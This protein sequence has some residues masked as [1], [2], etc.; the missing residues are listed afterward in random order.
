MNLHDVLLTPWRAAQASLRWFAVIVFGLCVT[1]AAAAAL[2]LH[3]P[4]QWPLAL[5]IYS[6]GVGF[7]WAFFMPANFLLALDARR[8]S[9]PAIEHTAILALCLIA[10]ATVLV[11]VLAFGPALGVAQVAAIVSLMVAM[12]FSFAMLP[13]YLSM[14]I[15]MLPML[16]NVLSRTIPFPHLG[17][18]RIA[19]WCATAA[20]VFGLGCVLSWRRL[21]AQETDHLGLTGALVMHFRRNASM[22]TSSTRG[23]DGDRLIRQRSA[24]LQPEADLHDIGPDAPAASIRVAL[25]G[26]LLPQTWRGRMR[27]W[28]AMVLTFGVFALAIL[29][30]VAEGAQVGDWSWILEGLAVALGCLLCLG[31]D[32][33]AFVIG[34]LMLR[35]RWSTPQRELALLA[36]LPGLGTVAQARSAL[37][38]ACLVKPLAVAAGLVLIALATALTLRL[39]VLALAAV[40]TMQLLCGVTGVAL[41]LDALSGRPLPDWS[42]RVIC[43][44]LTIAVITTSFIALL[45]S[46]LRQGGDWATAPAAWAIFGGVSLGIL[47]MA[48]WVA[49]RGG[50]AMFAQPHPFLAHD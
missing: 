19:V 40:T 17:D 28:L 30:I 18:P 24:W 1:G 43:S 9:M 22:G 45:S 13:I 44:L 48:T 27:Q 35:Q 38:R 39:S 14:L 42:V 8:L 41:T 10:F 26:W 4:K 49:W 31:A 12:G 6:L 50:R 33:G 15:G 5:M 11:A 2:L 36:L 37:L 46:Q 23:M 7:T 47:A 34:P 20:A 3:G 21:M 32:L 25:G 16:S 29:L